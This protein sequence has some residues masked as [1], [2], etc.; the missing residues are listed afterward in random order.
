[1]EENDVI[2]SSIPDSTE[3][4]VSIPRGGPIY[5]PNM[6][7]PSTTLNHFHS[8]LLYQLQDLNVQLLNHHHHNDHDH[9]DL[10]VHDLKVFTDHDLMDMALKQIFHDRENN[11]EN[12]PPLSDQSNA[13]RCNQNNS[14]RKRKRRGTNNSIL[15]SGCLEKVEQIVRIKHKQEEDKEAVR[16][17]SFNPACKIT[18]SAQNSTR[19]ERMRS[20]RST[21][22]IR[23][24]NTVNLQEH[25]PV[26]YPEVVLSVEVYHNVR[27]GVKTQEL[28]VLGGQTLTALR[29][30]IYCSMDHVMQKA[31][32]NDPSGYFLIEDVFY[33]DLRDPSAID[34]SRPILDWLQ[35]SKEEAQKK[36]E[37]IMNGEVHQ[38]QK[39]IMGEVSAP[40]LPHFASV[41]MDKIRFCDLRIR[42]GAGYLYCH[43][44]DCNHTLVIRDMRLLHPDDMHN[45]AVYPIT[46]FQ[47]KLIFQ[48]CSVCNIFR[49]TK[50]T[51]DDKWTPKN[52]C[53]FC[54][55]CFTLLHLDEDGSPLYHGYKEYDYNHG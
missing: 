36:W 40:D 52:P 14:R 2:E 27:R 3:C 21:S 29:D 38:K 50:V 7:S 19:I 25:I 16:L 22:S 46:T 32:Q 20:L 6:L 13:E 51:V 8:S 35:N 44:G 53:F 4:D 55:E 12:H 11:N 30:K 48:K 47:R 45:R 31:E 41:E 49:A 24:V 34:Y 37:Y 42:L 18:E 23:K 15:Q 5:V 10:S 33:N 28:L 39:S 43:Q 26:L 9:D 17:S 1:M 54:D